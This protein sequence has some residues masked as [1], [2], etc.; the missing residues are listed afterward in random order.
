[1]SKPVFGYT[2]ISGKSEVFDGFIVFH[3]SDDMRRLERARRPVR[4]D[5]GARS[6]EKQPA[7]PHPVH[8]KGDA[9]KENWMRPSDRLLDLCSAV[10]DDLSTSE[11]FDRLSEGETTQ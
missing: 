10:K 7:H 2:D 1:M 8:C 3:A 9:W 4:I 5:R 11:G 6:P